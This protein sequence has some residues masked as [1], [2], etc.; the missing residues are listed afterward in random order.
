MELA[1]LPEQ[2]RFLEGRRDV[3]LVKLD[4]NLSSKIHI[5][6]DSS[7]QSSTGRVT[8]SSGTPEMLAGMGCL[9]SG[10]SPELPSSAAWKASHVPKMS[11][12]F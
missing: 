1:R 4:V 9:H 2:A 7:D 11:F 5:H 10:T 8:Q 12:P 6:G 3:F